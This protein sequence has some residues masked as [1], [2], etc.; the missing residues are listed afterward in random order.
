MFANPFEP[1]SKTDQKEDN[2]TKIEKFE[3]YPPFYL[4]LFFGNNLAMGGE[5]NFKPTNSP[6]EVPNLEELD[7]NW[8][9]III[10]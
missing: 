9:S 1:D 8:L 6:E 3:G 2:M 10:K 5:R 7:P 4:G